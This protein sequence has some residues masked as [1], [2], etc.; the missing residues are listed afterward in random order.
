M[1][2]HVG[3]AGARV[4]ESVGEALLDDPVRREVDRAREREAVAVE[5]KLHGKAGA[6]DLLEQGIE[7]V[8]TRLGV[9]SRS[10]PVLAHRP[11]Q[12]AHLGKR[13]AACL[14]DTSERILVLHLRLGELVPDRADL[15][16][17]HAD[18]VRDDVMELSRDARPLL[19]D[20]DPSG[21][22]TLALGPG[23]TCFGRL[24]LL[25]AHPESEAR[26]PGDSEVDGKQDELRRCVAGD[27]VDDRRNA[28]EHDRQPDARLPAVAQVPEQESG[29]Q[30]DGEQALHGRDQQTVD[31][32]ERRREHPV[33]RRSAERKPPAGEERKH[34]HGRRRYGEPQARARRARRVSSDDESTMAATARAPISSSNQYSRATDPTR[35]TC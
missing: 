18:G 21:R 24:G 15:E 23:R 10:W 13:R 28:C 7:T 30:P 27:V 19:C 35:L 6:A 32:G 20:R 17:H 9:S 12:P 1:D 31:E 33:S 16:H 34:Q 11:E 26:G 14:L 3:V 5:V 2:G 25:A 4:L 22:L 29:G 8:E